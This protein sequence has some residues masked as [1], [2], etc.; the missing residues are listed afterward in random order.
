MMSCWAG[1]DPA[2]SLRSLASFQGQAGKIQGDLILGDSSWAV[3]VNR[4]YGEEVESTESKE[5]SG[6]SVPSP[7]PP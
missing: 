6:S 3:V 7:P 1:L 2:G 4:P 5:C